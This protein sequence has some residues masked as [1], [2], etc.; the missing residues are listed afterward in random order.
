MKKIKNTKLTIFFLLG[1]I[2]VISLIY[3]IPAV[4]EKVAWRVNEA[5]AQ[6][7]Y[8]IS[9]PEKVLFVPKEG[10]SIES[11]HLPATGTVPAPQPLPA[12]TPT[13]VA[14]PTPLPEKITLDGA[15]HEYQT[16]NNCGPATL[17]MALTYW[18]WDGDQRPIAAFTK[19]NSRDKN[20]MPDELSN[21]VLEETG[22]E[23][24]YRTGGDI[25]LIKRLLAAELPVIIEKGFEG[26]DFDGWM[27]HYVLVTGYDQIEGRFIVQDSYYG[28]DRS[29]QYE[30]LESNWRAFN[31][32]Y[33]V[34]YP[35]E[36]QKDVIVILGSHFDVEYNNR[37]SAERATEEVIQLAGRDQFFAWFNLGSS[38][39][40]LRDYAGAAVAY[41]KAFAMYPDI[42]EQERPWR[43][44]WYQTG[45]YSAYFYT[46]RYQD[47]MELATTTLKAMSEPVLEES[48]YWRAHSLE[49][50]GD[51]DGARTDLRTALK[52]H[53]GFEPALTRLDQLGD[54]P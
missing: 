33:L 53:P 54:V 25:E 10:I 6:I 52:Y 47:V 20:V 21:Y 24:V 19:P 32:T 41:D 7:K 36:R 5:M 43:M 50:L 45:P 48:Y 2:A 3:S 8:A 16:W 42:P 30:D 18:G 35:I 15:Q 46:G 11:P 40:Q 12:T 37:N 29:I 38:L 13:L 23:V 17:A 44:M 26:R 27:G 28:P 34:I 14:S 51:Y 9:P 1:S 39:V 4:R 22:L 31:F 49:A